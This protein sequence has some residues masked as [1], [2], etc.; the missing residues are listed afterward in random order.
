MRYENFTTD[1]VQSS[2]DFRLWKDFSAYLS[3]VQE[4]K[5]ALQEMAQS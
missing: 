2:K 1:V 5:Q 4:V 3:L